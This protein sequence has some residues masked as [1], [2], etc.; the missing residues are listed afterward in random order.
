M[1][2]NMDM[3]TD[4]IHKTAEQDAENDSSKLLWFFVGL[5]LSIF[6]VLVAYIYQQEPP[7]S[8]FLDKSQDWTVL[9]SDAYK[10]KLRSIQLKYSLIGFFITGVLIV[11]YI[12][13]M[14]SLYFSMWDE[15]R[16]NR[17]EFDNR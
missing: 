6:G 16:F 5:L 14:I 3:N 10:A 11:I 7:A 2:E 15:F 9:Y 1:E 17:Y 13:L 12:A 4:Q 8:R